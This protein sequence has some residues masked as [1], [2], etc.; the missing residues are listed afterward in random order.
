MFEHRNGSCSIQLTTLATVNVTA[1]PN[2]SLS[3]SASVSPVCAGAS[4]SIKVAGSELGVTYQLRNASMR[5]W[6]AQLL[7]LVV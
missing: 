2:L 4:S 1:T 6:V 5:M 7:V 3:T